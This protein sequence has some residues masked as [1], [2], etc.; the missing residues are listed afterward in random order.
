MGNEQRSS[1]VEV[2]FGG[3]LGKRRLRWN[4]Q[5]EVVS[6]QACLEAGR[7]AKPVDKKGDEMPESTTATAT[8]AEVWERYVAP[9]EPERVWFYNPDSEEYFFEDKPEP[10]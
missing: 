9:G 4:W 1:T 5:N 8:D 2:D 7:S 3:T 6:A 10:W